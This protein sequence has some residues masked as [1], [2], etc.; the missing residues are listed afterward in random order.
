MPGASDNW[1]N[2]T[3]GRHGGRR[4]GVGICHVTEKGPQNNTTHTF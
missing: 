4:A 1:A 3:H 2:L